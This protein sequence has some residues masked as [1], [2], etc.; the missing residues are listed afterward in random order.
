MFFRKNDEKAEEIK[1]LNHRIDNLHL[2]IEQ[3]DKLIGD[4]RDVM[5]EQGMTIECL[6]E[7]INSLEEDLAAVREEAYK[8]A[9][10]PRKTANKKK[11]RL[12]GEV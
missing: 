6:K 12:E 8:T 10:K 9:K 3:R 5:K 11:Q 7:V 2:A 4:Q 1:K